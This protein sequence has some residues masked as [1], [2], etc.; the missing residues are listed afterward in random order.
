M[1]SCLLNIESLSKKFGEFYAVKNISMSVN[2]GDVI[3][4]IGRNGA[5]KTTLLRLICRLIYPTSGKIFINNKSLDSD[6]LEAI[7]SLG[8]LIDSPVFYGNLTAYQNLLLSAKI[9]GISEAR[10]KETL[11]II[12]LQDTGKKKVKNFSLGMKQRLGIGNAILAN[13]PLLILDEPTN[14]LDPQGI[15]DI[16]NLILD[17]KQRGFTII[18]ASHLLS[19]V[20]QLCTKVVM[21]EN[22]QIIKMGNL[23]EL[24]E[25]KNL[26]NFEYEIYV[27]PTIP[28][29]Q[30]NEIF[31]E[32]DIVATNNNGKLHVILKSDTIS[33]IIFKLVQHG[34][35]IKEVFHSNK[36]LE[37]VFLD[38]RGEM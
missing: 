15:I 12:K 9:L 34:Y 30:W 35:A 27:K 31:G 5:G 1:G 20:E 32:E 23:E 26:N 14:G 11:E 19:E 3:A 38:S 18:I 37:E 22:G 13:P 24:L 7:R 6:F 16:R 4:I 29:E 17:L 2:K 25:S 28:L 8:A 10:I 36:N 33:D 21:M